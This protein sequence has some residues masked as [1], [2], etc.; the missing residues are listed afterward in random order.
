MDENRRD[1]TP[2][3]AEQLP[4]EGVLGRWEAVIDDMAATAEEYREAGWEVVALHPGDVAP[5]SS[6]HSTVEQAGIELVVPGEDAREVRDL[7]D[8]PEAAFDSC[9]VYRAIAEGIVFLVVAVEDPEGKAAVVF[10][11]YYDSDDPDTR[12]ALEAAMRDGQLCTYVRDLSGETVSAFA[13]D[14]PGLF[15]PPAEE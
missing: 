13:H 14:D 10:P 8:A 12:D 15:I 1:R 2:D 3:P 5:V 4:P 9:S 7:L 11:A 6:E